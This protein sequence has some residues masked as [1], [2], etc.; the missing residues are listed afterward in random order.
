MSGARTGVRTRPLRAAALELEHLPGLDGLR[1]LA[2]SAVL[3]FHLDRLPG[4]N[5]G[6]DGFFV[7]SG[8]L[9]TTRLLAEANRDHPATIN[10]PRFWEGRVR[11]LMPASLVVLL[12]VW[13]VW[14]TGRIQVPTLRHDVTWALGW[15]SNWGTIASG[16][17]YWARFG[18]P[19]PIAHFWSLAIEE[20]FY[21]VWPVL[22]A[23]LVWRG[24]RHRVRLIGA[25]SATLAAASVAFMVATFDPAKPTATYINTFARAHTLL[26]GAAAAAITSSV[27]YQNRL[28]P[29]PRLLVGGA[30]A[31]ALGILLGSGQRSTWLFAWGFPAFAV[32]MAV[33][34]VGVAHGYGAT[35]LAARPMRWIG[36][37]SYGIYL[38]H[39]PVFLLL[40]DQRAA[41]GGLLLDVIRVTTAVGLAAVSYTWLEAPIRSRRALTAR[42]APGLAVGVLASSFVVVAVSPSTTP[43]RAT[44]SEVA[45]APPPAHHGG[46]PSFS[47]LP[48]SSLPLDNSGVVP[49]VAVTLTLP[50][51]VLITGDSTAMELADDLIP[52]AN[53]HPDYLVAGSEAFPGCGLTAAADG[54]RH[55]FTA[56]DGTPAEVDLSGC[57]AEWKTVVERV[58]TEQI[59]IV[60]LQVASWDG[61]D[62]HLADGRTLSV[63]DPLGRGMVTNAYRAF[64]DSVDAAGARVVVVTPPDIHLGWGRLAAPMNDPRRWVELRKIIDALP[65]QQID[66]YSWLA[67]TGEDGPGGRP[68]GVHLTPELD[69][70][71][72]AERVVPALVTPYRPS[73]IDALTPG[74]PPPPSP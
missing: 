2:V 16:G 40:S 52:W 28:R 11:R 17:D 34:V 49:A 61:L 64:I 26:I 43:V 24:G 74:T 45:L 71:F 62:I 72:V 37:R 42:W 66:L 70:R 10:L 21:L 14:A 32:A 7:L 60:V 5:L 33:V 8:W 54:R 27:G 22:I 57:L 30:A 25:L 9:I 63:L 41:V 47:G 6:V 48:L 39:W 69:R 35:V 51:R 50:Q 29:P 1:A 46:T 31:G 15:S 67:A 44:R 36:D 59:D 19:S 58:G 65:V 4:G 38:W 18:E 68:D 73:T 12:T 56:P 13:V 53:A 23:L 20:Q 55:E 3:L